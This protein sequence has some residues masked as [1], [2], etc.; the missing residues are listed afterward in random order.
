MNISLIKVKLKN[1][2][3]CILRGPSLSD[4]QAILQ[5]YNQ[6]LKET[7]YLAGIPDLISEEDEELYIKNIIDSEDTWM[8]VAFHENKVVASASVS[9]KEGKFAHRATCGLYVLKDYWNL[10]LGTHLMYWIVNTALTNGYE[11]VEL[12]VVSEN[13]RAINLYEKFGF[14]IYGF[15]PRLIKYNDKYLNGYTMVRFLTFPN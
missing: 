7:E 15:K 12:T 10:G 11:Q 2:I 1:N 13:K 14:Q 3:E 6:A 4:T 5:S 8:I 9:G